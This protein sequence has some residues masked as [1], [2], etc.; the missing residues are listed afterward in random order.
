MVERRALGVLGVREILWHGLNV[1]E[2]EAGL[3]I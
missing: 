1:T 2:I 3:C